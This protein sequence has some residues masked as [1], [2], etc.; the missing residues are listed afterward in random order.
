MLGHVGG[1]GGFR[2]RVAGGSARRVCVTIAVLLMVSLLAV[3]APNPVSAQGGGGNFIIV[4]DLSASMAGSRLAQAKGALT[5]V[6]SGLAP[7]EI[8]LGLRTFSDCGSTQLVVPVAPVDP[9]S[10]VST[11]NGLS[12]VGGTDI[13]RALLAAADDLPGSGTVLLVSDGAHTCPPP[14]P[15]DAARTVAARGLNIVVNTVSFQ[16]A[17]PAAVAELACVATVT[18]GRSIPVENEDELSRSI[19]GVIGGGGNTATVRRG[20]ANISTPFVAVTSDPVQVSSGNFTDSVVDLS[21]GESVF[22]MDLARSYN[23]IT[24]DRGVSSDPAA[25][26]FGRGWRLSHQIT[27]SEET[28]GV[29]AVSLGSG[30]VVRFNRLPVAGSNGPT[31]SMA[32]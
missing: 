10:M 28:G 9:A 32:A 7:G 31:G 24:T 22:G 13:S 21:F 3:V 27:A 16:I 2:V 5:S 6:V 15:C 11:I 23:S 18:G 12:T 8:N 1:L 19:G 25:S 20:A 17:D 29:V 30:R 26:V 14:T 4:L